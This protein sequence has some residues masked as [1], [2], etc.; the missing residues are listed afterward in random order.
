MNDVPSLQTSVLTDIQDI[1][2]LSLFTF[3]DFNVVVTVFWILAQPKAM[4]LC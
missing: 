3:T 1:L 4:V 2:K